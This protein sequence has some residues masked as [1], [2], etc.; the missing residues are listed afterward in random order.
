MQDPFHSQETYKYRAVGPAILNEST[1]LEDAATLW[2]PNDFPY[3]RGDEGRY[4]NDSDTSPARYAVWSMGP[5]LNSP[6]FDIPGRL[7]LPRKYWLTG[8]SDTGVITHFEDKHG[9]IHTSP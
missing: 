6:K 7:P 9:R 4:I 1:F 8:V 2:V 5:D 3:G